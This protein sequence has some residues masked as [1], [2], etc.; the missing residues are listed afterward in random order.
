MRIRG[1][2]TIATKLM[3]FGLF[4]SNMSLRGKKYRMSQNM[5][6]K[7]RTGIELVSK[8]LGKGLEAH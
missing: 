1:L 8:Y 3:M 5:P 2:G 6:M 4:S 7:R